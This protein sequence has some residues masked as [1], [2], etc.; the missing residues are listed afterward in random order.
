MPNGYS[1]H[2][3]LDYISPQHYRGWNGALPSCVN[4]ANAMLK[5]AKDQNYLESKLLTNEN[6]HID[7]VIEAITE[8]TKKA[9]QDD[10]V[11]ITY[12]GHGGQALDLNGDEPDKKDETWLLYDEELLDDKIYEL[13]QLFEE[14]V[15][16]LIVSDS[17]HSGSVFRP[18][19]SGDQYT[20]NDTEELK[21]EAEQVRASV[22][23]LAACR[24]H[25]LAGAGFGLS[26]YTKELLKVWDNGKFE[27]DFS[28]LNAAILKTQPFQR[29]PIHR[30]MGKT[31]EWLKSGKPFVI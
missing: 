27:G 23:L 18:H 19:N 25:E 6:A 3:G 8:L 11:M 20:R 14:G 7:N 15:R 29:N 12:S 10:L 24:D 16:V 1:L 31:S 28:A 13:L 22:Q 5:I 30:T 4:D 17:C 26:K 21:L 9:N 2:I